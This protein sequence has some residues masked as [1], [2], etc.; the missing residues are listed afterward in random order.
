MKGQ[1]GSTIGQF[2]SIVDWTGDFTGTGPHVF[3]ICVVC[4]N[5]CCVF[6]NLVLASFVKYSAAKRG[7]YY[8]RLDSHIAVIDICDTSMKLLYIAI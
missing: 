7:S 4:F 1:L 8:I 3:N 2:F 6:L 5:V